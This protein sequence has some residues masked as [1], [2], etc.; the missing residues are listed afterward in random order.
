MKW[1]SDRRDRKLRERLVRQDLT[2]STDWIEE[3]V[4]YINHGDDLSQL[5]LWGRRMRGLEKHEPE[6][7]Q[8]IL[9]IYND[10]IKPRLV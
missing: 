9:E 4:R 3:R 1:L 6:T 7:Y 10:S 2:I 5:L 8:K